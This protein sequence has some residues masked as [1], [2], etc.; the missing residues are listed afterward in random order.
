MYKRGLFRLQSQ[1]FG[2]L[3]IRCLYKINATPLCISS[4]KQGCFV[5]AEDGTLVWSPWA[6]SLPSF[7]RNVY[8]GV[9]LALGEQD[10]PEALAPTQTFFQKVL[11]IR[12]V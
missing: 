10:G 7:H 6:V 3:G 8:L 9:Y 11:C 2:K 1:A 12:L 4:A 5:K